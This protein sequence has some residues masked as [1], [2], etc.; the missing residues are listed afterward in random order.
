MHK[1]SIGDL[2]DVNKIYDHIEEE[3][4]L[5]GRECIEVDVDIDQKG[6]ME[7]ITCKIRENAEYR[8][9]PLE[10][11][12]IFRHYIAN[13]IAD[14]II[15]IK[16]P[17]ILGKIIGQQYNYFNMEEKKNILNLAIKSLNEK[18]GFYFSTSI[19]KIGKKV[20]MI[21]E[22]VDYL[23]NYN[24]IIIDGFI[25]F[26]LKNYIEDLKDAVDVAVEDYLMER[27]YNEFI[28]LLQYFVDIQEPK[29]HTLH[30]LI[31][32][33]H[34]FSLLDAN[35]QTIKNEYLEELATEFLDG[36]IKY[37]DL[38]I[39]SLITI[40]P[41]RIFIHHLGEPYNKE[42]METIQKVFDQRVIICSGC[43]MCMNKNIVK[44]D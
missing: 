6:N 35:Y 42:I 14:Y 28:R 17:K 22:I 38:L 30:I 9:N 12:N 40:A 13:V 25:R 41:T 5:L 7:L 31:D 32:E 43:D 34:K 10:A 39:S 19:Y 29:I 1:L 44:K 21:E 27:E 3:V 33:S 2:E 37:E 26:R 11:L 18:E 36:E 24:E 15:N 23:E 4:D 8:K 20:K 16:E